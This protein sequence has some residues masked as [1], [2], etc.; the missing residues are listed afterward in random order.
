[1]VEWIFGEWGHQWTPPQVS[2]AVEEVCHRFLILLIRGEATLPVGRHLTTGRGHV[3]TDLPLSVPFLLQVGDVGVVAHG[4]FV[5]YALVL[6]RSGRSTRGVV[7]LS[8]LAQRSGRPVCIAYSSNS[9][10]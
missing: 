10:G 9:S 7:P 3:L 2:H 5:W 8:Q 4:R 6:H 1:M